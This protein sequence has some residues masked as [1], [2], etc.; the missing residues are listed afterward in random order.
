MTQEASFIFGHQ[1]DDNQGTKVE[2]KELFDMTKWWPE[3][4]D[5]QPSQYAYEV[6]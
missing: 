1:D 5:L 2:G 6:S 4:R 3:Q